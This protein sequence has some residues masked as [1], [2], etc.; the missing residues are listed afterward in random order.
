M[1]DNQIRSAIQI[2]EDLKQQPIWSMF[3]NI[4]ISSTADTA[5]HPVSFNEIRNRLDKHFYQNPQAW[6]NEMRMLFN[7]YMEIF[8]K[9]ELKYQ[10]V[11]KLSQDYE[12]ELKLSSVE[13]SEIVFELKSIRK[14]ISDLMKTNAAEK[15]PI[16]S[17]TKEP[18]SNIAPINEKS[19]DP[20]Q[21]QRDVRMLRDK[22][23]FV[24]VAAL[25]H[26]L[27]PECV[28]KTDTISIQFHDLNQETLL[29]T[30]KYVTELII[31]AAKGEIDPL[32]NSSNSI[33]VI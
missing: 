31:S 30:R 4:D 24:K 7:S 21:L 14:N 20:E 33:H 3:D 12:L 15:I 9:D 17:S 28:V 1:N 19:I 32:G 8:K 10:S 11:K 26:K 27:Q 18:F 2:M 5:N 13:D 6:V 22:S 29:A 25:V 23:L 16:K